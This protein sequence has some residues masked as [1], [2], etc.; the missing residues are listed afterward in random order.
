MAN[1]VFYLICKC[2]RVGGLRFDP[3]SVVYI[4]VH[5]KCF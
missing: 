4:F 3:E 2:F 1:F 5:S